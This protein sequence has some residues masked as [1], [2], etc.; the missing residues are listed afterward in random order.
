MHST[1]HQAAH[2]RER[3]SV[4]GANLAQG[5]AGLASAEPTQPALRLLEAQRGV[6][7]TF[8]QLGTAQR[9]WDK[10]LLA[11]E[12]YQRRVHAHSAA[13]RKLNDLLRWLNETE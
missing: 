11:R 6:T 5:R 9:L 4:K 7:E 13:E 2:G 1:N 3:F 10:G 12:D 8:L